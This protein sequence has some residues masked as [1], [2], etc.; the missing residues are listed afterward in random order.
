MALISATGKLN[1]NSP[2]RAFAPARPFLPE[3]LKDTLLLVCA[4]PLATVEKLSCFGRVPNSTL[5]DQLAGLTE[6]E[7]A[8]SIP[9]RLS[10][11]GA[12]PRRRYFI[13]LVLAHSV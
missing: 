10:V 11:F 3:R 2:S 1:G 4:T 5:R 13:T 9:H 12:H 8:D 6:L 7:L